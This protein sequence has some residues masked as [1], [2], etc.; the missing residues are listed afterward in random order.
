LDGMPIDDKKGGLHIHSGKSCEEA[1]LVG[2]HFWDAGKVTDPWS[3][4]WEKQDHTTTAARFGFG[5]NSGYTLAQNADHTVVVHDASGA[6]IGCGIL[7]YYPMVRG[8]ITVPEQERWSKGVSLVGNVAGLAYEIGSKGGI[9]VH[10]GSSCDEA[11]G[12]NR[13]TDGS[14]PWTDT[15]YEVTSQVPTPA[16]GEGSDLATGFSGNS[17]VDTGAVCGQTAKLVKNKVVVVHSPNGERIACGPIVVFDSISEP[18]ETISTV[19]KCIKKNE[20]LKRA[21]EVE[22][23][24]DSYCVHGVCNTPLGDGRSHSSHGAHIL[25]GQSPEVEEVSLLQ[26][27]SFQQ[28][29]RSLSDLEGISSPKCKKPSAYCRKLCGI[30]QRRKNKVCKRQCK[31]NFDKL[32]VAFDGHCVPRAPLTHVV[33]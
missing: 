16:G 12:H 22:A 10:E 18:C 14:D 30:F 5:V 33:D 25:E 27:K 17:R 3:T 28:R 15:K 7:E 9:H 23:F 2:G 13:N 26:H 8:Y 6:R 24:M 20:C 32:Q 19:L 29:V 1:S 11:G 4:M 21:D 31:Q